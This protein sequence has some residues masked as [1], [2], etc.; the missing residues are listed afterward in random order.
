VGRAEK[1]QKEWK[2]SCRTGVECRFS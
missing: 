2:F 1:Q